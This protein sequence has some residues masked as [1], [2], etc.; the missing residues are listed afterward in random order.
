[1]LLAIFVCFMIDGGPAARVQFKDGSWL[2]VRAIT[3][4]TNHTYYK[5][6]WHRFVKTGSV[7]NR[8]WK[9]VSRLF[10]LNSHSEPTTRPFVANGGTYAVFVWGEWDGSGTTRRSYRFAIADKHGKEISTL[11]G[12]SDFGLGH[13]YGCLGR[14]TNGIP[15]ESARILVFDETRASS[16]K[17]K[18]AELQFNNRSSR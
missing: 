11:K 3:C 5:R 8:P 15:P 4:G 13:G 14:T 1:M 7:L 17:G 16:T 9:V 12:P 18:I 10:R 2:E 6:S